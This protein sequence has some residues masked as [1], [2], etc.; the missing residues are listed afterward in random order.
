[1]EQLQ[2]VAEGPA[3]VVSVKAQRTKTTSSNKANNE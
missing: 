2:A 1:M 3:C